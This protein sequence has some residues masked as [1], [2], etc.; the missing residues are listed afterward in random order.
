MWSIWKKNI[1]YIC[2]NG[3]PI[4]ANA[5]SPLVRRFPEP[6]VNYFFFL[7]YFFL[8]FNRA[9]FCGTPASFPSP[10]IHKKC[11]S[12]VI[13]RRILPRRASFKLQF[14]VGEWIRLILELD[15]EDERIADRRDALNRFEKQKPL[16][17]WRGRGRGSGNTR[18]ASTN[19]AFYV[20]KYSGGRTQPNFE[21][22]MVNL[23]KNFLWTRF[24]Q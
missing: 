2:S 11:P 3:T 4:K 24:T 17:F 8:F 16:F 19:G 15:L 12:L 1:D 20:R 6:V 9:R 22:K 23:C 13:N 10:Q 21:I 14:V 18:N 5:V 7:D